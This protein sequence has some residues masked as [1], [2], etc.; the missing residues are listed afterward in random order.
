[1]TP[2]YTECVSIEEDVIILKTVNITFVSGKDVALMLEDNERINLISW[3]NDCENSNQVY[4]LKQKDVNFDT[5][6]TYTIYKRNIEY[7]VY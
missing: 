2:I 7:A 5:Y 3:L 4:V 1:L 6:K